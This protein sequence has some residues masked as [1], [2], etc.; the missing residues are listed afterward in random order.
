MPRNVLMGTLVTRGKQR[1]DMEH[2]DS[3]STAEW[4]SMF[5][6]LY[7]ELCSAV[8]GTGLRYFE[9]AHAFSADGSATY[10]LPDD[11]LSTIGV[12]LLYAGAPPRPLV[13]LMVQERGHFPPIP[14]GEA[15]G[16]M[17]VAQTIRLYP[18]PASGNYEMLYIPQP[19]DIADLADDQ[20]VDV[21][22]E[23]GL[24]FLLWGVKVIAMDKSESELAVAI[25]ERDRAKTRVIEWAAD[26]AITQP[27]RHVSNMPADDCDRPYDPADWRWAR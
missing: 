3:I 10:D 21:V 6:E 27:R 22:V 26:R 15:V 17:V 13:D 25:R 18:S 19:A 7:G 12:D 5:S 11:H 20:N 14:S 2:D 9:S 4:K 23:A 8:D 24:A 16:Y 1:C